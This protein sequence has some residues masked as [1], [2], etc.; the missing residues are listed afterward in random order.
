MMN[1]RLRQL[2]TLIHSNELS[3]YIYDLDPRVTYW[4][5]KDESLFESVG[6]GVS[7]RLL[8]STSTNWVI[9]VL[10]NPNTH[11][12]TN[13]LLDSWEI[14]V[15]T[16]TSV[17]ITHRLPP[18]ET[19]DVSFTVTSGISNAISLPNTLFSFALIPGGS[20]LPIWAL[21]FTFRPVLEL[22]DIYLLAQQATD[23]GIDLFGEDEFYQEFKKIWEH[24][25]LAMPYRLSALVLAWMYRAEELRTR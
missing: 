16:S 21:D 18:F 8:S 4:P 24:N 12:A 3:Q 15:L 23:L 17:R 2:T 14:E 1:Y 7:T 20:T 13:N 22:S 9:K 5:N 25:A 6:F 19:T 10:G 11:K